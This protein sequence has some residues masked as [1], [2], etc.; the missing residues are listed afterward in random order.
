MTGWNLLV[1]GV[2]AMVA[3]KKPPALTPYP[4]Q[5]RDGALSPIFE[6][7]TRHWLN[8]FARAKYSLM[9]KTHG[10]PERG[11]ADKTAGCVNV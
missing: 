2:M 3:G 6:R 8:L 11:L 1:G 7:S 10:P 4:A 9:L 5:K